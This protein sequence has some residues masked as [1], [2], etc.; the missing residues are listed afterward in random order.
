VF[1]GRDPIRHEPT[2]FGAQVT[3]TARIEPRTPEGEV[4]VTDAF[5]AL[6]RLDAPDDFACEYVGH[7]PTAKG[8][9][10]FPMYRLAA[11]G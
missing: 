3:K 6:V 8:Y 5:A 9:G 10:T 2:Y 1:A 4:Y 11:R 7:V